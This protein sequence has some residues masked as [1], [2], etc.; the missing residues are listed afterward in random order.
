MLR[1]VSTAALPTVTMS[2]VALFS[3]PFLRALSLQV[4]FGRTGSKYH[5]HDDHDDDVSIVMI[6]IIIIIMK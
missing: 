3:S 2:S 4:G 1:C 5:H 6:I